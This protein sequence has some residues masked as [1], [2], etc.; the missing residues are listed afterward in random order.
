MTVSLRSAVP[1]RA[2][3]ERAAADDRAHVLDIL[4]ISGLAGVF[5]VNALAALLQP[6]D[7][8]ELVERSLVGRS[9]S[10]VSGRWVAWAIAV[11]DLTIG[12]ALLATVWFTR[13]RRF[14]LAWAGTWLLAVALVKLTALQTLGG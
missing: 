2:S 8:T 10:A 13:P 3:R 5:L 7:F 4:L 1:R 12:V 6:G 9:V 11:H 14:V